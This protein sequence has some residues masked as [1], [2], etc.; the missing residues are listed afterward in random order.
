MDDYGDWLRVGLLG[1]EGFLEFEDFL[2]QFQEGGFAA[3]TL[4]Y[5]GLLAVELL[6]Q[7]LEF[8]ELVKFSFVVFDCLTLEYVEFV[9]Q[10]I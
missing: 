2:L 9:S 6:L 5:E 3:L 10:E 8:V 1:D 7:L 4:M